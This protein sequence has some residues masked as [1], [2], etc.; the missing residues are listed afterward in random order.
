MSRII[1]GEFNTNLSEILRS[2]NPRWR[3]GN[4][5]NGEAIGSLNQ[6]GATPDILIAPPN[7]LP[8]II[9]SEYLPAR[10]VEED[11]I[12]RL[13]RVVKSTNTRI[14]QVIALRAPAEIKNAQPAE[15]KAAILSARFEYCLFS[16]PQEKQNVT[17]WPYEGWLTGGVDELVALIENIGVSE[18][19]IAEGLEILEGAVN[20]AATVLLD[21]AKEKPDMIKNIVE[22][23]HQ[24][25]NEQT[26]RMATSIIAN[27]LT[28]HEL[29]A[30][31]HGVKSIGQLRP[32]HLQQPGKS[33]LPVGELTD[34][35]KRITD[36]VNYW[37]IFDIARELL[38]SI[39]SGLVRN[40]LPQLTKAVDE[41]NAAGITSSHDLYGRMFQR[42]ITDRK[43]LATFYTLPESAVLLAEVALNTL[44]ADFTESS[45]APNLRIAD[46]ACGSGTLIAAAY[47]AVLARHRRAGHDDEKIHKMMMEEALIATDIMPAGVHLTASILSSVHPAVT[48][49]DTKVHTLP[50]GMD[51]KKQIRLGALDLI[52]AQASRDLLQS[53]TQIGGYGEKQ[54]SAADN[55]DDM[56][57]LEHDDFHLIIMN[58]PFTRPTNHEIT[59][60]PVPSFAGFDTENETQRKM[61]KRLK[62]I[63]RDI[64]ERAGNGNAGLASNFIDLA[65][66]K[67]KAGG[68]LAM[69]LPATFAWGVGW[70]N[71]R[72]LI[73]R[74]YDNLTVISLAT[75]D[76][77]ATAFSAD[78]S[79]AEILLVGKKRSS[80]RR[81]R[82]AN[83]RFVN[84]RKR[85]A[86]TAQ[87][88]AT[89]RAIFETTNGIWAGKEHLGE[90]GIATLHG[91][92]PVGVLASG[93]LGTAHKLQSGAL[94]FTDTR[95]T[96]P[97]PITQLGEIAVRGFLHRDI[98]GMHPDGSARGPFKIEPKYESR[99]DFP[100]LWAHDAERERQFI[101]APDRQGRM[102]KDM[103]ARGFDVWE[104]ATTLHF[105]L[106]FRLSAG[107]IAACVTPMPTIGGNA[108]PN[109]RPHKKTHEAAIVLWA[110]STLGFLLWWHNA[111]RQQAGRA[112]ISISQ[113]PDL[114]ILDTRQLTAQQHR[115]AKRIFNRF[116]E[117]T[118]LPANEAYRD[119]TRQQLDQAVLI[120][121]LGLPKT[122]LQPLELLRHKWCCE[123]SVHGGKSTRPQ[124]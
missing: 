14:E 118:F 1:E 87:A 78:T 47:Q 40:I 98:N 53:R 20:S 108:W 19:I 18:Q 94:K 62:Q 66:L 2:K 105:T 95:K 121:L 12:G 45:A 88:T 77:T 71:A 3:K 30:G 27:A 83:V 85:P 107:S 16:R 65:H 42:L 64:N 23:L 46:F 25:K 124:D 93:L 41:I 28:F 39:P 123:P 102:R 50:F 73:S 112:R 26:M 115:L 55:P 13:G 33:V 119:E 51:D 58:P 60:R 122:I 63:N 106:D 114:P 43:F 72:R 69:V 11:A 81:Q 92:S 80:P 52:A 10:T 22:L 36:D 113:L 84:L 97:I 117:K 70:E 68:V 54:I 61:A 37:P 109:V 32:L 8:V 6:A 111:S 104:T 17:R 44:N 101:V 38:L 120:E 110:N 5:V 31:Q 29:L 82:D 34:E 15:L 4:F 75:S 67:L 90:M 24:S 99:P 49:A 100:C 116:K 59:D 9:E 91:G 57:A 7:T 103:R 96:H 76:V 86:N 79:I 56:F 89:A 74:N 48:F 35:W 21:A